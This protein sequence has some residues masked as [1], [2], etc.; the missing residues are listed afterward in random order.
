VFGGQEAET[1]L[2]GSGRSTMKK[3]T[4]SLLV[5]GLAL[6]L[7]PAEARAQSARPGERASPDALVLEVRL[8]RQAIERQTVI[9]ARTQVLATRLGVQ[10]ERV[11]RAQDAVDGVADALDAATGR[12]GQLRENLVQLT[13]DLT[14]VLHEPKRS[15]LE[16]QVAG[17][18]VQLTS[19]DDEISRLTTRRQRAE[20]K[21]AAEQQAYRQLESALSS[22]EQQLLQPRS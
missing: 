5:A 1:L 13:S 4:Y 17:V 11:G 21:L 10:Q 12:Q 20:L 6:A 7:W 9:A 19:Q 8:L 3:P 16:G 14:R 2:R 15:E 22:L 18:K